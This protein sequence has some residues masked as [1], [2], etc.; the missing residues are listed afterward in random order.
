MEICFWKKKFT[1]FC[2]VAPNESVLV[3]P[4]TH[5]PASLSSDLSRQPGLQPP[6]LPPCRNDASTSTSKSGDFPPFSPLPLPHPS[7][8]PL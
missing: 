3:R 1:S 6:Q 4:F 5:T 8:L 2:I 7:S